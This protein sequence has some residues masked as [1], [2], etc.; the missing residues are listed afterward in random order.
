MMIEVGVKV[1]KSGGAWCREEQIEVTPENVE[2]VNMFW[3]R[4][5]FDSE[6]KAA[7]VTNIAHANYNDYQEAAS[8]GCI[9]GI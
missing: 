1:W 3:N 5:Y 9:Y 2:L 7:L 8:R 4:L 6:N